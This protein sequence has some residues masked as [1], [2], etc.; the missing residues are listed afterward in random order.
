MFE[1]EDKYNTGIAEIDSQHKRLLELG[2]ELHEILLLNDDYDHY[3]EIVKVLNEL[4]SYTEY[5]FGYEE[6]LLAKVNFD[7]M[8]TKLHKAE[9]HAFVKKITHVINEDIDK[10][11]TNILLD[12]IVFISQWITAHILETDKKYADFLIKK[13]IC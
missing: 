1:W 6:S 4:G 10:N 2:K 7:A 8:Q 5:H 3:D 13:G 11:Q 12:T 9:H